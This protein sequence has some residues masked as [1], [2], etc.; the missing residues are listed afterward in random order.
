MLAASKVR[1]R[2]VTDQERL[3]EQGCAKRIQKRSVRSPVHEEVQFTRGTVSRATAAALVAL[4]V[5]LPTSAEALVPGHQ[6]DSIVGLWGKRIGA[7]S[8]WMR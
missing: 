2:I 7:S 6:S 4:L 8:S 1:E 3:T 5:L